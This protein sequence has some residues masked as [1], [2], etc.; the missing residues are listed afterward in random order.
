MKKNDMEPKRLRFVSKNPQ[1]APWL[2]LIEGKKGSKP[3]LKVLPQLY[4]WTENGY[5]DEMQKIIH[6]DLKRGLNKMTGTLYV[7]G[8]PIGNMDDITLRQLKTLEDVDFIAAEDTRVTLKLLNRYDIK[9]QLISYHGHST[10]N[11]AENIISRIKGG[12]NAA[13]VTDAGMPC[14]SDPGEDW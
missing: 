12:E 7:V 14:I 4:V 6:S 2:F 8:T 1:S 3:Y 10:L 13:V 5:T 11:C 9:K